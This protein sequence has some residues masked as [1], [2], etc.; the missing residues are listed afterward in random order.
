[1]LRLREVKSRWEPTIPVG[2]QQQVEIVEVTF[3]G[4][5]NETSECCFTLHMK[6]RP[7]DATLLADAQRLLA[8][9]VAQLHHALAAPKS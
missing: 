4:D 1:M 6:P 3:V 9:A 5:P 2:D 7:D 8:E